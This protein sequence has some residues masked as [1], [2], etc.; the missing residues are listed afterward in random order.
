MA[1]PLL[2]RLPPGRLPQQNPHQGQHTSA[3]DWRQHRIGAQRPCRICHRPALMRDDTGQPC[4]KVCA[5]TT[6]Q[7]RA[8][9]STDDHADVLTTLTTPPD[10]YRRAA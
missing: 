7:H 6:A 8:Y 3:L 1:P 5:E 9:T 4:H 2:T 10:A